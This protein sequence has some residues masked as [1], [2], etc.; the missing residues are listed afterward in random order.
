MIRNLRLIS[1]SSKHSSLQVLNVSVRYVGAERRFRVCCRSVI[2]F[3]ERKSFFFLLLLQRDFNSRAVNNLY[4]LIVML[5][6]YNIQLRF[7]KFWKFT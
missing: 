5:P 4:L 1:F 7:T 2:M 3:I 6:T